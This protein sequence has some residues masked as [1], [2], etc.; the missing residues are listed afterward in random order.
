MVYLTCVSCLETKERDTSVKCLRRSKFQCAIARLAVSKDM[1]TEQ[2]RGQM[3]LDP[4][5]LFYSLKLA[6]GF[7]ETHT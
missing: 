3:V 1:E 4:A 2:L 6:G 5:Y 7:S